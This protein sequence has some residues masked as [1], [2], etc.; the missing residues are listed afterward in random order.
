MT[1]ERMPALGNILTQS[2]ASIWSGTAYERFR[3]AMR[4]TRLEACQR[5]DQFLPENRVLNDALGLAPGPASSRLS[6]PLL[7]R[8]PA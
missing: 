8:V 7:P 3:T 2:L 6:L 4:T 1:N 5:C